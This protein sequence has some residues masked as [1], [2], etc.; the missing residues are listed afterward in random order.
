MELWLQQQRAGLESHDP[1][2]SE[3]VSESLLRKLDTVDMELENQRRALMR[4]QESG[5]S[6]Q[7]L[8]HPQRSLFTH[9]KDK[10]YIIKGLLTVS[11]CL[12]LPGL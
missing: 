3:E 9:S 7:N 5:E 1:G 11:V 6:L 10:K 2:R 12:Q 4:L 8:R